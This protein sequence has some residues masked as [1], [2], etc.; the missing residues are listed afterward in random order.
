LND[1]KQTVRVAKAVNL[2]YWK[3]LLMPCL[4]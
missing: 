1:L 3:V 2:A 4:L